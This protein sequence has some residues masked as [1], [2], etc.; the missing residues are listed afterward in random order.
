MCYKNM[1]PLLRRCF[2]WELLEWSLYAE[3]VLCKPVVPGL[4]ACSP[5]PSCILCCMGTFSNKYQFSSSR[6]RT[7]LLEPPR[8]PSCLTCLEGREQPNRPPSSRTWQGAACF[9]CVWQSF[10]VLSQQMV[11]KGG[12]RSLPLFHNPV[13]FSGNR[14]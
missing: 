2:H 1:Q 7:G 12:W 6:M 5:F 9:E 14:L 13:C 3:A 4:G 10:G 8:M 11:T